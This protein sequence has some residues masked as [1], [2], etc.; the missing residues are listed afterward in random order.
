MLFKFGTAVSVVIAEHHFGAKSR[1]D[2]C[3]VF[4]FQIISI[5]AKLSLPSWETRFVGWEGGAFPVLI[6]CR[7]KG[8]SGMPGEG[9]FRL[10][11][12]PN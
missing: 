9:S 7:K 1:V 10:L 12:E 4:F 11:M 3:L 8:F 2:G 6:R 5:A